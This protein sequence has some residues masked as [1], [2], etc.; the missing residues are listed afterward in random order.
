MLIEIKNK[1]EHY[2]EDNQGRKQGEYKTWWEN[3]NLN[4][5]GFYVNDVYHGEYKAFRANGKPFN[6]CFNVNGSTHGEYKSWREDGS[7][8]EHCFYVDDRE[9]SFD[10]IP[11]PITPEEVMLFKLKYN[12][13]LLPVEN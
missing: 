1:Y 8:W 13:Q 2:F 4:R 10:K 3:G 11:Y 5:H 7:V 6:H 9:V 12:L